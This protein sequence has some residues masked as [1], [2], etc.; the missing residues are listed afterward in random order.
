MLAG[1]FQG[2]IE[3]TAG[4][5]HRVPTCYR[6]NLWPLGP[7]FVW[8]ICFCMYENYKGPPQAVVGMQQIDRNKS[9]CAIINRM[10]MSRCASLPSA[11]CMH[12]H[13]HRKTCAFLLLNIATGSAL[14]LGTTLILVL[15]KNG[16]MSLGVRNRLGH[17]QLKLL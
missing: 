6:V 12:T 5:A 16:C 7:I 11:L 3:V 17:S 14:W 15:E 10:Q 4:V 1:C 13:R 8:R 2:Y 9:I